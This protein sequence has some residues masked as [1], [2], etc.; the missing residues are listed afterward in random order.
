MAEVVSV[1]AYVLHKLGYSTTM[2]LQK[3]VYYSQ[4]YSLVSR[5]RPLFTERIEA[6]VNG[7]VVPELFDLHRG[8]FVIS[9]GFFG[10]AAASMPSDDR[11][12]V[13]HVV[14]RL[15]GFSGAELSSLSHSEAPWADARKGLAPTDRC[16]SVISL[17]SMRSYYSSRPAGNP[18]F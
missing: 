1:A 9:D 7:P 8:K 6:W 14:A 11:A 3:I 4:A 17:E 5:N 10:N 16:A 2:K 15:G 12:V 13:D 18:A